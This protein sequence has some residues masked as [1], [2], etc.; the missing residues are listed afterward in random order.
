MKK[1]L[2]T[3]FE[4]FGGEETN[5][6]MTVTAKVSSPENWEMKRLILPVVFS[7]AFM[8]VMEEAGRFRPD[9]ILLT[10]QAGS[11]SYVSVEA[12][13]RNIRNASIP[14]NSGYMPVNEKIAVNG[15]E[16]WA[17]DVDAE[18]VVDEI[19]KKGVS[20][21]L[22]TDA[23]SFVCNDVYYNVLRYLRS[24]GAAII[25]IHLP[26][27]YDEELHPSGT[28]EDR[29]T[30]ALMSVINYLTSEVTV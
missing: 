13:A 11:R 3:C 2:I 17:T 26:Y 10:G 12:M 8:K 5:S 20:A 18:A 1:I 16:A 14:D 30:A 29:L 7:E 19:R 21:R 4:P 27:V 15:Q 23:G 28:E 24:T 6:S 25:F 9:V 22:S